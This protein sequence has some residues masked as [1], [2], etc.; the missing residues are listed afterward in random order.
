MI[1]GA[2]VT[3]WLYGSWVIA[4][5]ISLWSKQSWIRYLLW[6]I[7]ILLVVGLSAELWTTN[8]FDAAGCTGNLL[9]GFR[10]PETSML[11]QLAIWHQTLT[12]MVAL[13][14]LFI[15]PFL[16]A[17]LIGTSFFLNRAA[18]K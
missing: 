5:A 1:S 3:V 12:F 11:T 7:A 17:I 18:N 4:L 15:L 14:N 2:I 6:A 13:F 16:L 9:T 8:Q 10:C